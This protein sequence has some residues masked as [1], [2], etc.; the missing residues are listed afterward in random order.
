[1]IACPE[2]KKRLGISG[3][4]VKEIKDLFKKQNKL[5]VFKKINIRTKEI[6]M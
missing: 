2:I 5:R 6:E 1:M 4:K 3:K